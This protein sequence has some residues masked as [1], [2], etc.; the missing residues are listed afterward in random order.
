[1]YKFLAELTESIVL[2]IAVGLIL[3]LTWPVVIPAAFPGLV[4]GGYISAKLSFWICVCLGILAKNLSKNS[5]SGKS[6]KD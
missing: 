5:D 2:G 6:K 1:M 4:A 3:F